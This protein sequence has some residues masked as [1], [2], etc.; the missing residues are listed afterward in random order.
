[1]ER[2]RHRAG[3]SASSL[4]QRA[5]ASLGTLTSMLFAFCSRPLSGLG[6]ALFRSMPTTLLRLRLISSL[7]V[8]SSFFDSF[9]VS[10]GG[11]LAG[12]LRLGFFGGIA[13]LRLTMLSGLLAGLLRLGFFGGLAVLFGLLAGL[14]RL[15]LFGGLAV[16]R[17]TMLSGLLA[18]LLRLG[19]FG[20][21]AVLRLT[22]FLR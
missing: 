15:G 9:T 18:G 16:L 21:L 17:L 1:M 6:F 8:R 19:F 2:T 5:F 12:L 20:G 7:A 11:L 4:L 3:L 10:L 13:V 14:L 22:R